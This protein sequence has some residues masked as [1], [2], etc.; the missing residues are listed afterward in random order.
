MRGAGARDSTS[1][2]SVADTFAQSSPR[3]P[4]ATAAS[5]GG[6]AAAAPVAARSANSHAPVHA[7]RMR[8]VLRISRGGSWKEPPGAFDVARIRFAM[9]AGEMRFLV[10]RL[11]V[12]QHDVNDG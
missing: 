2:T 12:H 4:A 11:D 10:A 6:G 9:Q 3:M 1:R 8:H 5:S 7:A